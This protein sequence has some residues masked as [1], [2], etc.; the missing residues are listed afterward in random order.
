MKKPMKK[1]DIIRAW[2]DEDYRLSPRQEDLASAI[3][4]PRHRVQRY[5]DRG[6]SVFTRAAIRNVIT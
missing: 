6:A 4:R 3:P 5:Q 1:V 2:Q